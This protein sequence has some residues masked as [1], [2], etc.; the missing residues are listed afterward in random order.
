VRGDAGAAAA[1][2]AL[3]LVL[4]PSNWAADGSM[5]HEAVVLF[6]L[7]LSV[8]ALARTTRDTYAQNDALVSVLRDQVQ[9]AVIQAGV[10]TPAEVAGLTARA[11]AE[12]AAGH[13]DAAMTLLTRAYVQARRS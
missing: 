13:S 1:K 5:R 6:W 3:D 7:D 10:A 8:R 11:D 4:T 9:R 2:L 12:L